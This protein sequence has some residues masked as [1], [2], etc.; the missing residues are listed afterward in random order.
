VLALSPALVM[1]E[2]LDGALFYSSPTL[3]ALA[4]F[5]V[6]RHVSRELYCKKDV[7]ERAGSAFV[8]L[9]LAPIY[10]WAMVTAVFARRLPFRTTPKELTRARVAD[11][12]LLAPP[13]FI[14]WLNARAILQ[15]MHDIIV[16]GY[17]TRGA[18]VDLGALLLLS[19]YFC[20]CALCAVFVPSA[21]ARQRPWRTPST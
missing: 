8:P 4:S 21:Y 9:A 13:L 2:Q 3:L 6:L 16:G 5:A 7:L 12:L 10:A 19:S 17:P 11:L 15:T 1:L 14:A 18:F 20:V